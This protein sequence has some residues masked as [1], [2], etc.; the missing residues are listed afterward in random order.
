MNLN[1]LEGATSVEWM[2][3]SFVAQSQQPLTWFR[4]RSQSLHIFIFIGNYSSTLNLAMYLS[5]S[6]IF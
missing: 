5:C 2:Q 4:V 1:S 6:G 3:G